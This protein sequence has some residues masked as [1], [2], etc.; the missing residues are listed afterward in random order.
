VRAMDPKHPQETLPWLQEDG[1][2]PDFHYKESRGLA[3]NLRLLEECMAVAGA[4]EWEYGR[5]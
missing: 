3:E 4:K 5:G 2:C 1:L